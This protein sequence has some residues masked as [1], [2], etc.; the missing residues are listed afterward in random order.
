ME[1]PSLIWMTIEWLQH[2]SLITVNIWMIID[3]SWMNAI[4][5]I[6]VDECKSI[7]FGWNLMDQ[8]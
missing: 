1:Q 4:M 5:Q 3:F 6:I 7:K 8:R 2:C